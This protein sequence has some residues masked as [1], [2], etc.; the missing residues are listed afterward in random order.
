MKKSPLRTTVF[1]SLL[2]V[3]YAQTSSWGEPFTVEVSAPAAASTSALIPSIASPSAAPTS[4]WGD[5]FTISNSPI[6]TLP[7]TSDSVSTSITVETPTFVTSSTVVSSTVVST[8][9]VVSSESRTTSAPS[10]TSTTETSSSS[11]SPT[12]LSETS[13]PTGAAAAHGRGYCKWTFTGAV[14]GAV[15]AMLV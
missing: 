6:A 10:R 9:L 7:P 14:V 15:G 4:T 13:Q 11:A 3:S 12:N 1:L 5:P 8:T 2:G